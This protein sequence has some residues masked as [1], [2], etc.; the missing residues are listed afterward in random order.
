KDSNQMLR[1]P[2]LIFP[3]SSL[4]VHTASEAVV[5]G[6]I[7]K[8]VQ[9]SCFYHVAQDKDI[10]D[11]CWGRGS[12]PKSKCNNKI[13]HTTGDRVTFRKS[14]RYSLRGN[15]SSG[16]VSLTIGRVKAEDAG[17]YCCRVEIAGWFNDIKQNIQ[18]EVRAPPVRITTT[19][20]APVSPRHFRKT[21]F[22]PQA[23]SDHQTTAETA[24]LLTTNVPEATTASTNRQT[25]AETAVLLTTNVPEETTASTNR[26][27]TAETAVLLT[28]NV[29]EATTA[30]TNRQTTAET[31]V[32]IT[33]V[34]PA[35]TVNT[36]T[37]AV[38]TLETTA[39]PTFAV[40]ANDTF[41]ATMVTTSALPDFSTSFQA[42][43]M[44][45]EDD[46]MFC[47]AESV[48]LP[49]GTKG[50]QHQSFLFSV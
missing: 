16:D 27:T 3:C 11:M 47:P 17:T 2:T 1:R 48:T 34:P 10:S 5:R 36:E 6:V 32:L 25:T 35:T 46:N 15:I 19:R 30:T 7:G 28:T 22:A 24:V 40:T 41:P 43:D 29:P 26:Q 33:T 45:T 39:H 4:T 50:N 18:L 42:A 21:T 44:R 12:C 37:P 38:I 23:T 31:A 13:L 8:P 49:G 20:K 14:Q 9:L